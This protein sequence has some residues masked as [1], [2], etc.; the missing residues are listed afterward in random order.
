MAA[1]FADLYARPDAFAGLA[2]AGMTDRAI[3]RHG[4]V[5]ATGACD[6]AAI[7]RALDAYL[8]RLE[9]ELARTEGYVVFP[10]VA[11]VLAR[12]TRE[13]GV[14]VGLG[15]GNVRRGAYAKLARGGLDASFSFGGFGCDAE[16]RSELLRAGA[17]RGA[18]ALGAPMDECRVVVIGDTP[19]D[20]VAARGIG[21]A[22][23]GVGTGGHAPATLLELGATAAF[24]TLE[25][26]D[27][28]DVLLAS[29]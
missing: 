25:E 28:L 21:A 3:V 23:V 16:D 17:R 29:T 22:C 2:F 13:Q 11:D 10:G 7:D 1:A 12:V 6:E 24:A 8:A 9:G 4:I 27:V 14:A 26:P 18:E 5:T 20:V 15:T 19:R